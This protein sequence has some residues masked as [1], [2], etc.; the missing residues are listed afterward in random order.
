VDYFALAPDCFESSR[1]GSPED[2]PPS[3]DPL[4]AFRGLN[5]SYR[6]DSTA[7][8]PQIAAFFEVA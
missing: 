6:T 5:I 8:K 1:S 4:R 3:G 7:K 2:P